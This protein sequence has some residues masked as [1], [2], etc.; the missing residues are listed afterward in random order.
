MKSLSPSVPQASEYASYYSRYISLVPNGDIVSLLTE[1]AGQTAEALSGLS[2]REA[3]F[4]YAPG[5]WTIKQVLGHL[6]DSERVFA[7]R[8]LRIARNDKTPIEGFEQD[9]YV[10]NGPFASV[11]LAELVMEFTAVRHSTV[12]LFRHLAPEGWDRRGTANNNEVTVRATAYIIAGHELHHLRI[13]QEKYLSAL[14]ETGKAVGQ[15]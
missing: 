9:D 7:Y 13:L 12:L 1:Q 3:D 11:T 2:D 15:S 8:A 10:A 6:I 14:G 5:K 4:R